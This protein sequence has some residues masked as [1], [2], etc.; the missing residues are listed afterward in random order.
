MD[1][2][3]QF[4]LKDMH[5]LLHESGLF[6]ND[7][8]IKKNEDVAIA[9][10]DPLTHYLD[11]GAK[12]G[13]DPNFLFSNSYYLNQCPDLPNL[14]MSALA[15][16]ILEGWD[17]LNPHIMFDTKFYLHN[18]PEVKHCGITPLAHFLK[19]GA[20]CGYDPCRE[21]DTSFYLAQDPQIQAYDLNPLTHYI[22]YGRNEGR[23]TR[24]TFLDHFPDSLIND[25]K[26]LTKLE[27]LLPKVELLSDL[28]LVR[29]R[30]TS[31]VGIAYFKL[32]DRL[33]KPFSQLFILP[34]LKSVGREIHKTL[35]TVITT[36]GLKAVLL[37]LTDSTILDHD[38]LLDSN[39]TIITLADLAEGLITSD[40]AAILLKL[41]IQAH[42]HTVYNCGSLSAHE[43][44]SEFHKPLEHFTKLMKI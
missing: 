25:Y 35:N 15:H 24:N 1:S 34:D 22:L 14:S 29:F 5:T 37:L 13:R 38:K 9:E 3:S 33:K 2:A 39:L 20:Y 30:E 31:S 43:I 17:K 27:P 18:Y 32:I 19:I 4:Q 42:P 28:P 21:F 12:E 40:K 7:F 44:F 41:I 8:Y 10:I 16:Y 36:H 6:D 11:Y 26:L 23:Y